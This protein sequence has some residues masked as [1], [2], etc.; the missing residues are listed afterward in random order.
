[1]RLSGEVPS[2]IE[3]PSGCPFHTRCPRLLG[4]I[5]RTTPPPWREGADGH[6]VYCHIPLDELEA[7]QRPAYAF[8][9]PASGAAGQDGGREDA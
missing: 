3:P 8:S 1:M 7:I 2:A 5:C 4:D 6:G 9:H